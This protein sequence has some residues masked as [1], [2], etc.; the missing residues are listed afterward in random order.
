MFKDVI[1]ALALVGGVGLIAAILLAIATHFFSIEK[2]EIINNVRKKLPGINCGAC[3]Y[4]GCDDYAEAI[5]KNGAKINSCVPGGAEATNEIAKLMGIEPPRL[6]KK[7]AFVHC[8][9]NCKAAEHKA[10]YKGI[11]SCKAEAMLYGGSLACAFG[12]LGKGDCAAACPVKAICIK[13]DVAR[14]DVN[15]CLGC[16]LCV[17]TCPKKLIT[18][19]SEEDKTVVMCHNK[20]RGA[21]VRKNCKN[22]CIA[23]GICEKNCP[24]GAI[25][26][27]DLL[28][29]I[30]T[31]KCTG[32]G[33]CV[34]KCPSKCIKPLDIVGGKIG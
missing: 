23:C 7:V 10:E 20:E 34:E 30:D 18:L 14:I 27:I 5:A 28:A 22:G 1:I 33:I 6:I 32:C 16:G 26:L 17:D 3:G 15:K 19:V 9:G 25:T 11:L 13:D 29:V 24:E 4:A 8:N 21:T 12:C 2:E 31:E